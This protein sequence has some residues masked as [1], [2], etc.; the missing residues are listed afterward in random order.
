ML[1]VGTEMEMS[2][3]CCAKLN[4]GTIRGE[5][6]RI[7]HASFMKSAHSHC[8]W[9]YLLHKCGMVIIN[10][11]SEFSIMSCLSRLGWRK[12]SYQLFPVFIKFS[13][14][15]NAMELFV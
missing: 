2:F 11:A 14:C 9:L 7:A 6:R 12:T 13:Q 10:L 8:A 5:L 4:L 15:H 1:L 3:Q